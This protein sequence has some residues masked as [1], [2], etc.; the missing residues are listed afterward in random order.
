MDLISINVLLVEDNAAD[1]EL[2]LRAVEKGG[3]AP[4]CHAWRPRS[5]FSK[6]SP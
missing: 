6:H 5:I 2:V 3:Y 4:I 1:A